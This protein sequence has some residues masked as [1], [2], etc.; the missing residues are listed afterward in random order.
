MV[1]K[2]TIMYAHGSAY[3]HG[4]EAIVRSTVD[5]PSLKKEKTLLFSNNIQGDLDYKI[6]DIVKVEPINETD[7][8]PNSP[9]G[10]IYRVCSRLYSDHEKMYHIFF[11]KKRY[12]YLYNRG[13][14][15]TFYWW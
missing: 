8:E 11:G 6:D 14:C 2:E 13:G 7:V 1:Q 9:L 15:G 10:I 5:L 12:E 4:C 3:N